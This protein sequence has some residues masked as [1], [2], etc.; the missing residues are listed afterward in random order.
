MIDNYIQLNNKL[1]KQNIVNKITKEYFD[2]YN[3]IRTSSLQ[4]SYLRLGFLLGNLNFIPKSLLDVGY[5]NGDFL[6]VSA[7]II[8]NCYGYDVSN[9]PAP[10]KIKKINSL[11]EN[12]FD[13]VT[14]FDVLEHFDDVYDIKNIKTK[15][16]LISV[17]ECHYFSDD[18]F[19]NWKHR[20]PNEHIW[21][22]N[23]T[24]LENFMNEINFDL[25]KYSNIEDVIRKPVDGNTNI[26]TGLFKN[27]L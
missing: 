3:K 24:S 16:Y 9:Y 17:P 10:N 25:V 23:K 6:T 27:K 15:Y 21:H 1:I 13:V 11:Y 22:F 18:W 12:T 2:Y 26:L 14:L 7:D 4:I 19:F 5:G 8:E 20:K